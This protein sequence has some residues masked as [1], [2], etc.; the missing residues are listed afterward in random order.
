M[1]NVNNH[2]AT[3]TQRSVSLAGARDIIRTAQRTARE[4][5]WQIAVAV[6]DRAG[7]LVA[8]ERDAYRSAATRSFRR[9]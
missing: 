8:L 7:E 2:A 5:G 3:M 1:E 6:V 4:K 9:I